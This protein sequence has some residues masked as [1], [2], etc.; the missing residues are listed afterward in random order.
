M[1]TLRTISGHS[2]PLN[3]LFVLVNLTGLTF[4]TI[5]FHDN[6]IDSKTLFVSI[7][8]TLMALSVIGLIFFKG[9]LLIATVSRVLV[10]ALFIVSGLIKAN[11]PIGFS[12]KLEE[13]FEDGALAFRIKEWFG[14]PGFSLEFL[15]DWAL[16]LSVLI[17]I[18]EI[19]IGVLVLIGGKMRLMS[20]SLMLMMLFFTFLTWHTSNCDSKTKFTDRDTYAI[21]SS[22]AQVKLEESKT[23][24]DIKIIS[25]TGTEIVV[26]ELR[27]PQ[28]VTDCGCFGDA[29]KGSVGRSLS[30]KE[31]LWKD[32]I[33]LY[34]VIWIFAAQRSIHP[35]SV[36]QNWIILPVS[37]AFIFFF[38]WVFGWY[39]PLLF[40]TVAIVTALWMYRSTI[41]YL[42]NHF[43][44]MLIVAFWCAFFVGYVLRY[45]PLKDYRAYAVGNDLKPLTLN[46]DPGKYVSLLVYKNLK[47]GSLKEFDGAS[48]EFTDSKI[49]EKTKE[50]KYDTIIVKEIIPMRLPSIDTAQ[51]NPSLPVDAVGKDELKLKTIQQQM[52][53]RKVTGF[54]I[55]DLLSSEIQEIAEIEYNIE[56]YPLENYAIVDTILVDNTELTDVSIRNFLFSAPKVIVVFAKNLVEFDQTTLPAIKQI[57][58]EANKAGIQFV[59]VTNSDVQGIQLFKKKNNFNAP[60]FINDETELKAISRSNPCVMVLKKGV[61]VGKYTPYSLPTFSWIQTTL[62]NK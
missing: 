60:I 42:N 38:S 23:N 8:I 1:N 7:G 27:T 48:K 6:F 11:D 18:A 26:D 28:C 49:W 56:S 52:K 40:S 21:N 47:D 37:F 55:K 58:A 34:L 46:G 4:T 50:W 24:K 36:A 53:N 20:W 10:G 9:R 59:F 51:F 62:L 61:V 43:G 17:C 15:I 31:S 16:V 45:D 5:G 2:L 32:L 33:L 14:A 13:Y 19:V 25:K 54:Q 44:S 12:Y 41:K 39:F 3:W 22:T 35:N 29:M 30:P 57:F